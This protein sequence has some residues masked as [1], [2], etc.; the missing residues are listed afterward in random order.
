MALMVAVD[1]VL[2][3]KCPWRPV[4]AATQEE[5]AKFGQSS[6]GSEVERNTPIDVAIVDSSARIE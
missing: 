4:R 5:L 3:G 2:V 1:D 6:L